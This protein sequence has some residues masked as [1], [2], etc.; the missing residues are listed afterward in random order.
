MT[1]LLPV[2]FRVRFFGVPVFKV[3]LFN[4]FSLVEVGPDSVLSE[5]LNMVPKSGATML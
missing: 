4:W 3:V 2:L 1:H 5:V